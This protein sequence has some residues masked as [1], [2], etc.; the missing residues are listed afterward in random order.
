MA[1][2]MYLSDNESKTRIEELISDFKNGFKVMPIEAKSIVYI[3]GND[4]VAALKKPNGEPALYL[5]N[6]KLE[7]ELMLDITFYIPEG[8]T[9]F[10][11]I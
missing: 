3:Y 11:V 9:E 8:K 10:E 1:T 4:R 5:Q 2:S 6:Q 7:E